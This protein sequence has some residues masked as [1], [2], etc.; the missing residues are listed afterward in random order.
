MAA[1][2]YGLQRL[3]APYAKEY[4]ERWALSVAAHKRGADGGSSAVTAGLAEGTTGSGSSG[5]LT[6]KEQA[7]AATLAD[8]IKVAGRALCSI[9]CCV[10]YRGTSYG[11]FAEFHAPM[12]CLLHRTLELSV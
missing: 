3:V 8:A 9:A 5:K 4:Y 11:L 6:A 12:G 2:A 1:G 7:S 10:A